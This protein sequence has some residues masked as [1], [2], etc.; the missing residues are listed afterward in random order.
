MKLATQCLKAK[1]GE[2]TVL[3]QLFEYAKAEYIWSVTKSYR[4]AEV[5]GY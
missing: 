2:Q 5:A 1:M 3:K 4:G